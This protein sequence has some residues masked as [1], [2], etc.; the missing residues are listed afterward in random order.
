MLDFVIL[1][2]IKDTMEMDQSV[3]ML[4]VQVELQI[5]EELF[6]WITLLIVV[7]KSRKW[8]ST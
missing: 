5:V 8:F 4:N 7:K 2:V 3:G 1:N 6:V